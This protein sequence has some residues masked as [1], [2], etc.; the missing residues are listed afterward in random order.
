M[1][2]GNVVKIGKR[3]ESWKEI[4][5]FFDRDERTVHRWEKELGMPV[6][7]LPGFKG[8][9][10]AFSDELALWSRTPRTSAA[11]PATEPEPA[12][13]QP[14]PAR[15]EPQRPA[16]SAT[17][18]LVILGLAAGALLAVMAAIGLL[19][20][21]RRSGGV[22][23]A[24]AVLPLA[25]LSGDA[26]Q[27]YFADGMTDELTTELA[28]ISSL[29]V[30]SRTSVQQYRDTRKA[31]P[32]VGREL[33]VDAIVEGSVAKGSDRLRITVQL[34]DARSDRHVWAETLERSLGDA[35]SI[36]HQLAQEIANQIGVQL[37][38]LEQQY[39]A[40]H[41]PID[42]GSFQAYLQGRYYANKRTPNALAQ[43][44][45]Y[46]QDAA[47]RD[48]NNPLAEA[49]LAD[50]YLLRG[51]YTRMSWDEAIRKTRAAAEKAIALDDQIAEAHCSAAYIGLLHDWDF[52]GAEKEF[53][54]ALQLNPNSSTAHQWYA[55]LLSFR[56]SH[57][58]ALNEIRRAEEL[59]PFSMII[60][61]EAGQVLQ[62]AGQ[63]RLALE[64][65]G[66]AEALEPDF[67]PN[68]Y[69]AS[70]AHRRLGEYDQAI[71]ELRAAA[72]LNADWLDHS[73]ADTL[74]RAYATSGWRGYLRQSV[75]S[76]RSYPHPDYSM[77]LD[78]AD[79]GEPDHAFRSLEQAFCDRALD[80]L[81]LQCA[82]EF[83]RLRSDPRYGDLKKRIGFP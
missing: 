73:V 75:V 66:K 72:E 70:L 57:H 44:E 64:E 17:R 1:T 47:A 38:P 82:P 33:G 56:T 5:A 39:F 52:S 10:Y 46:F 35:A 3:L 62:N 69:A 36:Q 28:R 6:Y 50:T 34:V 14:E 32:A 77:A 67:F 81:A 7:R 15:A 80:I 49:G 55:E 61:H 12:Q 58:E 53:R 23:R 16:N 29:S 19:R 83:A 22:V 9:V 24:I 45:T 26:A 51:I 59:D 74:A 20:G 54:R 13:P 8:R 60:H 43:A 79:L 63:Y 37:T 65:Y 31:L 18:R 4:A 30:V 2:G 78:F 41:H 25:N 27:D 68:H 42:A 76:R 11:E 21:T 48:P 71:R 40:R